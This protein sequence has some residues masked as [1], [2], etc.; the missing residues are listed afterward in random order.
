M[1]SSAPPVRLLRHFLPL[2]LC[3]C[4]LAFSNTPTLA[5]VRHV[6]PSGTGDG[7]S[8]ENASPDLAA[9]LRNAQPGDEILAAE[10]VYV[11]SFDR[12]GNPVN[13]A[14]R[15]FA[16]KSGVKL[17]GGFP[18]EGSPLLQDR[19]PRAF[20]TVLTGDLFGDDQVDAEGKAIIVGQNAFHVVYAAGVDE[21]AVLDGFVISGGR[22]D[23]QGEDAVGGGM[24]CTNA[25]PVIENC[26]FR[27]NAAKSGGGGM[28]NSASS[29]DVVKCAFLE[30]TSSSSGGGMLNSA[31]GPVV[32]DCLFRNNSIYVP[33]GSAYGGGMANRAASAP[34]VK[35]CAFLGNSVYSADGSR[36]AAECTQRRPVPLRQ[37]TAPSAGTKHR[38]PG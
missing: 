15:T 14:A 21:T 17:F 38:W 5:A 30:N 3:L 33:S 8:W 31:S 19:D 22:A 32:E 20:P 37:S 1:S 28:N 11:P 18:A 10:G 24:Y 35:N 27:G 25:S 26:V 34:S 16:L 2:F 6:R 29:P 12:D 7:S 4:S 23:G 36:Y 9:V 13:G